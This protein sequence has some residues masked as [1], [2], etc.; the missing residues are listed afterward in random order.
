MTS[1]TTITRRRRTT[2]V[3][4]GVYGQ[5]LLSPTKP[6]SILPNKHQML[7]W[8]TSKLLGFN[9]IV[10]SLGPLKSGTIIHLFNTFLL[11]Q[12][13]IYHGRIPK[14]TINLPVSTEILT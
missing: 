9:L 14:E 7:Q 8:T 11:S 6:H 5:L 2:T 12:Q 4:Q 10:I 1:K 3:P 13:F